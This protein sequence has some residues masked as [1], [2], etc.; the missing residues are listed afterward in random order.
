MLNVIVTFVD[1]GQGIQD[2]T[3]FECFGMFHQQ[4]THTDYSKEGL[5]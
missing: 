2:K 1:E 4:K 3:N 5:T